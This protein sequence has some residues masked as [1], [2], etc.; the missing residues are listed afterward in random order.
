M[1]SCCCKEG[2]EFIKKT[3]KGLENV[4]DKGNGKCGKQEV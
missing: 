4:D 3:E 1:R 2:T